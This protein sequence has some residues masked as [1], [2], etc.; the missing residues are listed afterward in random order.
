MKTYSIDRLASI[1]EAITP[2]HFGRRV[3]GDDGVEYEVAMSD[4]ERDDAYR[5]VIGAEPGPWK[6]GPAER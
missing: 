5:R 4:G 1:N 2:A 6:R 3:M